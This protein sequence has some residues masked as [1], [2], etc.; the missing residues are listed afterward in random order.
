MVRARMWLGARHTHA[1][2]RALYVRAAAPLGITHARSSD[3]GARRGASASRPCTPYTNARSRTCLRF[4]AV[5]GAGARCRLACLSGTAADAS[6]AAPP[7]AAQEGPTAVNSRRSV[8]TTKRPRLLMPRASSIARGEGGD[9]LHQLSPLTETRCRLWRPQGAIRV[10]LRPRG[11]CRGR[12][13]SA[14]SGAGG[15]NLAVANWQ[16]RGMPTHVML[17]I[18]PNGCPHIGG[19][20]L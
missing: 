1:C 20:R 14:R 12:C 17:G 15:N 6:G 2:T 10:A 16:R 9:A 18:A 8:V 3:H 11:R 13:G 4:S 5:D 19:R 7:A